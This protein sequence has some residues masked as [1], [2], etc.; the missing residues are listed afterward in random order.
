M[1]T[2][3][4]F[5][6]TPAAAENITSL[7]RLGPSRVCGLQSVRCGRVLVSLFCGGL[8][9]HLLS[10]LDFKTIRAERFV[11]VFCQSIPFPRNPRR[12]DGCNG[13]LTQ[14]LLSCKYLGYFRNNTPYG[15]AFSPLPLS[16]FP[17]LCLNI[18][19][20]TFRVL[21]AAGKDGGHRHSR[22]L[23]VFRTRM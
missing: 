7:V 12:A 20:Y 16:P 21:E 11:V 8:R 1:R 22:C 17:L 4:F 2:L 23:N 13:C 3:P 15:I 10:S 19:L 6:H 18:V 5:S 14:C 9:P